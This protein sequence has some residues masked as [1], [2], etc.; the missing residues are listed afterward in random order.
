MSDLSSQPLSDRNLVQLVGTVRTDPEWHPRK[1]SQACCFELTVDAG[2]GPP[3]R[4]PVAWVDP[5]R[6]ADIV[7]AGCRLVVV[8][9]LS[10]RFF[11]VGGRTLARTEV[12]AQD[13]VPAR[14]RQRADRALSRTGG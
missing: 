9:Q 7:R 2:P 10:Q 14:S 8:G 12:L 4:V 6:R 13:V 5:P 1:A 11:R 3:A